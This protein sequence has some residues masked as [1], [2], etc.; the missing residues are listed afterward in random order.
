MIGKVVF[1]YRSAMVEAV[2]DDDGSWRG[3]VIPCLVRPL[4]C[5]HGARWAERPLD[6]DR[7][8]RCLES[9]ALWLHG[10]VQT[11]SHEGEGTCG[12]LPI[13]IEPWAVPSSIVDPDLTP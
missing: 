9:A 8:R 6:R 1:P 4:N 11:G 12:I 7:C 13:R 3:D 5:L 2:M 10:Q